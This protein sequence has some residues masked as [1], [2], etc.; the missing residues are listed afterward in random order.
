MDTKIKKFAVLF[1]MFFST[2][3]FSQ[4]TYLWKVISKNGKYTSYLYGTMHLM[5]ESFY[6]KYPN[7]GKA[8]MSSDM[9]VTETE[10]LL[11]DT[12]GFN[13]IKESDEIDEILTKDELNLVSEIFKD[14]PVNFR[15]FSPSQMA[16]RLQ[17]KFLSKNCIYLNP[18]DQYFLD[19]YIQKIGKDNKKEMYYLETNDEQYNFSA[20]AASKSKP[21][22][23][24]TWKS[25]KFGIKSILKQYNK[26]KNSCS[27][28]LEEYGA[29][30]VFDYQLAKP[31]ENLSDY[32]MI[33]RKERNDNWMKILPDLIEEKNL[34]VGV[35][36]GH[37]QYQCGIIEQLKNLGYSVIPVSME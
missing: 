36:L 20:K 24:K 8:V 25:S 11:K 28:L 23:A 31:C 15:K 12:E 30:N 16:G 32:E 1:C 22:E 33:I 34:F 19:E 26:T 13:N 27:A 6:N 21:A 7:L 4:H 2:F 35:G 10:M 37:F 3:I 5:G 18:K 9:I 29:M 14:D 17:L